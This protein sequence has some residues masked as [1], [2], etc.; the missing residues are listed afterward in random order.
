MVWL[1]HP[2][3]TEVAWWAILTANLLA[4]AGMLVYFFVGHRVLAR[5]LLGPGTGVA[6]EGLMAGLL[7]AVTVA[8]WFLLYDLAAGRPLRT[9]ALLG[10]RFSTGSG[11]SMP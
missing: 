4:A 5:A 6:R 11:T 2:V 8:V 3:L 1:V 10:P 7:V 9:P